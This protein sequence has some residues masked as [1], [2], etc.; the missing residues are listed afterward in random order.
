MNGTDLRQVLAL[1]VDVDT[2]RGTLEGVPALLELL[3]GLDLNATF[4][5]C[6]GP[7]NTGRALRRI[8]RRGF[9]GKVRRTSVVRHYGWRTLLY[10]VLLPGPHIGNRA[11]HVMR[12][13]REAGHEVGV[14]AYDHVRWQDHVARR[15][16]VWTER[17]LQRAWAAFTEA[18]GCEPATAGAAGWQIN[19][20]ALA[21]EEHLGWRYVSDVRGTE[22]FLPVMDGLASGCVQLPTTLPTLDELIGRDGLTEATVA[23]HLLAITRDNPGPHVFT[24]HAEI[25]GMALRPVL[26]QLLRGWLRQGW[27]IGTLNDLFE[28]IGPGSLSRRRIEWREVPG[29]AGTLACAG[30]VV[31]CNG[32]S[33]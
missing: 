20:H 24:L 17:E 1:K 9:V 32:G 33:R 29:R 25:E 21:M 10:G 11:G 4:L 27:R 16:A 8:F 31:S 14:H 30:D 19:R 7:D 13:T 22:P 23:G 12:A 15:G 6:V 2:C 26:R 3:A 5:F 18:L 28:A